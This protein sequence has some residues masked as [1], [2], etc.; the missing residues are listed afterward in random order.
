MLESLENRGLTDRAKNKS[1]DK[2]TKIRCLWSDADVKLRNCDKIEK[3]AG[4]PHKIREKLPFCFQMEYNEYHQNTIQEGGFSHEHH[5][6]D[7]PVRGRYF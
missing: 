5:T 4:K 7:E 3:N 6:T 1:P 2:T